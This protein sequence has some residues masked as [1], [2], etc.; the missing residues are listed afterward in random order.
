[1]PP[2][3]RLLRW[4]PRAQLI[5]GC[6]LWRSQESDNGS[7][8]PAHIAPPPSRASGGSQTSSLPRARWQT[9]PPA[10]YYARNSSLGTVAL[11]AR[12]RAS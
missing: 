3:D 2:A 9:T 11:R 12:Q 1:M 10:L 5:L 4:P 6:S 8:A 7:N